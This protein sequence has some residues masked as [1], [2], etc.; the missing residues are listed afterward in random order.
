MTA[1]ERA[2]RNMQP[3]KTPMPTQGATAR[4][5]NF[6]EVA[7]GYT[8]EEALNEAR[9]C[10]QCPKR[11]CVSGCPVASS[12]LIHCAIAFVFSCVIQIRDE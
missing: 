1:N 3:E 4:R 2:Q 10:I 9:R 11:P 6:D 5:A 12:I 7:L 8:F